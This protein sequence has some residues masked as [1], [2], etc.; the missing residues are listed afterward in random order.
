MQAHLVQL[1]PVWEDRETNLRRVTELLGSAD[2]HPGD[3]VLLPEMFDTGFSMNTERTAD[4]NGQCV[5]FLSRLA[6]DLGVTI[7]FG[8]TFKASHGTKA[9]NVMTVVGASG[10][11]IAEYQKIHPFSPGKEDQFFAPG[12]RVV[13]YD[14]PAP[15]ESEKASGSSPNQPAKVC[16]AICYDLRFPELFRRGLLLGAE[17]FAVGACWPRVRQHHWRS[18]LIARAIENQA[19][20][21][22]VNRTGTEP[23]QRPDSSQIHYS[24][25]SVAIG[26]TGDVLGEAGE[27]ETVLTIPLDVYS[28]RAWREKFPAWREHR[29]L[30][31]ASITARQGLHRIE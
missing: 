21:L 26:P 7:Q 15:A 12:D 1:N 30:G 24:G 22:G 10:Q 29:L 14:V 11:I 3:F 4:T 19:I 9:S 25:G 18:L 6:Q 20:V 13:V 16:A 27:N 23:S 17:I 2:M 28:V 8:R 5:Q 31:D